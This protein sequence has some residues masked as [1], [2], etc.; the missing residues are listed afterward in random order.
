MEPFFALT[1]RFRVEFFYF[2]M[3]IVSLPCEWSWVIRLSAAT[4]VTPYWEPTTAVMQMLFW[5]KNFED[6]HWI[7]SQSGLFAARP[8]SYSSQSSH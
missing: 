3:G 2:S 5:L 6:G 8:R 4:I 7:L 1:F